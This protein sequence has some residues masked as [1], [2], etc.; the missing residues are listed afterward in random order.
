MATR[1]SAQ[2]RPPPGFRSRAIRDSLHRPRTISI[3]PRGPPP[4]SCTGEF[5]SP[6]P[7]LLF[8]IFLPTLSFHPVNLKNKTQWASVTHRND[9]ER[10]SKV[11][12]MRTVGSVKAIS[13]T[14]SYGAISRTLLSSRT[15][16]FFHIPSDLWLYPVTSEKHNGI[17]HRNDGERSWKVT[18]HAPCRLRQRNFDWI[19]VP[20]KVVM[21]RK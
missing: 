14:L 10:S 11:T 8:F 4:Y 1:W 5:L 13:I 9:G 16:L 3:Y 18:A 21:S 12:R 19:Y 20:F 6:P 15:V 7:P 2:G 17:T